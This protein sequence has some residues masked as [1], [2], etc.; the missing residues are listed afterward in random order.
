MIQS[1]FNSEEEKN[2]GEKVK[3]QIPESPKTENP[4]N[5]EIAENVNAQ[6]FPVV[7]S[8][9]V[10]AQINESVAPVENKREEVL[11]NLPENIEIVESEPSTDFE[12]DS[13]VKEVEFGDNFLELE[14]EF[15]KIEEEV[16]LESKEK[17]EEEK[18]ENSSAIE[19]KNKKIE[20]KQT[21]QG[22][23]TSAINKAQQE[24]QTAASLEDLLITPEEIQES[25]INSINENQSISSDSVNDNQGFILPSRIESKNENS[26]L[27]Q[28]SEATQTDY[29]P[30][31]K[32]ATIR[33]S[34]LAW[35][36][37][38]AFFG[39]V[40]FLLV[41]G[42]I[43]DNL[44]GTSPWMAVGGVVLGSIIGFIQLFRLT[45]QILKDNE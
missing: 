42:W 35:S 2:D 26:F 45:S 24:K 11:E 41:I 23:F 9:E 43:A 20:P 5:T 31:S 40:V 8:N 6:Q 17:I 14:K 32:A 44:L 29:K 22:I 27:N 3:T 15:A 4:I 33:K 28:S 30:E 36:A 10:Q 25:S 37:G 12:S 21:Q 7:G 1:L 18:L 13:V 39:S 19:D 34:G 38:I 16:R